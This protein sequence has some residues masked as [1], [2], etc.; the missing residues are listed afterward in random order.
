MIADAI[1]RELVG[2]MTLTI[3]IICALPRAKFLGGNLSY[4]KIWR[5]H[6]EAIT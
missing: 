2:D 6:K 5:G 3:K 4:S 1:K